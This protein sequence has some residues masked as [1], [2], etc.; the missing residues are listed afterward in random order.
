MA[1]SQFWLRSWTGA[2]LGSKRKLL[3]NKASSEALS[4]RAVRSVDPV[5]HALYKT[6]VFRRYTPSVDVS[7]RSYDRMTDLMQETAPVWQRLAP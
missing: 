4:T 1:G 6:W 7:L 2:D 5:V 3:R